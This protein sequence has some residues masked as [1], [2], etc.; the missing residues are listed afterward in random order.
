MTS[1]LEEVAPSVL[2]TT[3]QAKAE[4]SVVKYLSY[5]IIISQRKRAR[6]AIGPRYRRE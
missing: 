6:W 4:N 2:S 3:E 1:A 5:I